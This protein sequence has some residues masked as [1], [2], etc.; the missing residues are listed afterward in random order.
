MIRGKEEDGIEHS[1]AARMT[2][3]QVLT[4]SLI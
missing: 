3:M 4:P 1:S 2:G